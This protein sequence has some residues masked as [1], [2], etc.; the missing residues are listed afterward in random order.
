[1]HDLETVGRVDEVVGSGIRERLRS[2]LADGT[3]LIC[4]VF[5]VPD[6]RGG[7]RADAREEEDDHPA[8]PEAGSRWR[9]R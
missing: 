9:G 7:G 4:I 3:F 2:Q 1:M 8:V 6:E 5:G